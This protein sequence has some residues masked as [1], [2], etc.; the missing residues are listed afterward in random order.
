MPTLFFF[1][2]FHFGYDKVRFLLEMIDNS[3]IE[4]VHFSAELCSLNFMWKKNIRK[5]TQNWVCWMKPIFFYNFIKFRRFNW[6]NFQ[7]YPAINGVLW[8]NT[9]LLLHVFWS[10]D[11]FHVNMDNFVSLGKLAISKFKYFWNDETKCEIFKPRR[12]CHIS[13]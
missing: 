7:I 12:H 13:N 11:F 9:S 2:N 5:E 10:C 8:I 1:I 6:E 4:D 3:L